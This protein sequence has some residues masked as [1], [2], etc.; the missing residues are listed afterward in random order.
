MSQLNPSHLCES[1]S[2]TV[3][4]VGA[5]FGIHPSWSYLAK[6]GLLKT[7]GFDPDPDE[8]KRL[9]EKY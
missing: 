7:Y 9:R 2:I 3:F 6:T 1:N 4:D 5:R 8:V